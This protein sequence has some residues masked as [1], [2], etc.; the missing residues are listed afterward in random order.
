MNDHAIAVAIGNPKVAHLRSAQA[1]AYSIICMVRC[2]RLP[3]ESIRR[4]TL[5]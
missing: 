1:V 2:I 4:A 5:C 3:A